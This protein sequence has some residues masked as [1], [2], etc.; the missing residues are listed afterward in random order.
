MKLAQNFS[1][2]PLMIICTPS[3]TKKRKLTEYTNS[4]N[5]SKRRKLMDFDDDGASMIQ[6]LTLSP[7]VLAKNLIFVVIGFLYCQ[8][9]KFHAKVSTSIVLSHIF[10]FDSDIGMFT[11]ILLTTYVEYTVK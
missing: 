7:K 4:G 2:V 11:F 9:L 8:L 5:V 10:T 3:I 1:V 6:K